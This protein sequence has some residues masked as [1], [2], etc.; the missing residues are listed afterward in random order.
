MLNVKCFTSNAYGP[1]KYYYDRLM[2]LATSLLS[3]NIYIS[4][5]PENC[6]VSIVLY[7][8]YENPTCLFGKKVLAHDKLMFF[9]HMGKEYGWNMF[10]PILEEYY[11]YFIDLT[12]L[13]VQEQANKIERYILD[14]ETKTSV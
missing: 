9:S 5:K 7:G 13:S 1:G 2:E 3:K 6:D 4:K 10:R 12:G 14:Y 11:D 8:L